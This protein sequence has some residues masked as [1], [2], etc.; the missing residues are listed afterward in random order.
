MKIQCGKEN[1]NSKFN[2]IQIQTSTKHIL[3]SD[4]LLD[5][6]PLMGTPYPMLKIF[7]AYLIIVFYIGPRFMKDRQPFSLN[8]VT[9]V[10]NLCQILICGL[11]LYISRNTE[12]SFQYAWKCESPREPSD[13]MTERILFA[14]KCIW[15]FIIVR[16]SEFLETIFFVLRKKQNQVSFLHVYHHISVVTLVWLQLKYVT[17]FSDSFIALLNTSVHFIMYSYYFLS[18]FE[19]FKKFTSSVKSL[20]TSIQIIQ[21]IVIFGHCVRHLIACNATKLYYLQAANLLFL[22]FMFVKFYMK[23]Y[24]QHGKIKSS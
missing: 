8:Y 17:S 7:A 20:I 13:E 24:C 14:Y 6:W 12:V 15:C 19:K 23:S 10:Y 22:I 21:L 4:T 11:M 9:R 1:V 2:A 16:A 18:S 3:F 5:S